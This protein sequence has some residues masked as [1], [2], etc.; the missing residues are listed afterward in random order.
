MNYITNNV[1]YLVKAECFDKKVFEEEN[2]ETYNE[3]LSDNE[4]SESF[5]K[6]IRS[7]L[8]PFK[9]SPLKYS[10][11]DDYYSNASLFV[12]KSKQVAPTL[13]KLIETDAYTAAGY[14]RWFYVAFPDVAWWAIRGDGK[15]L[16][17]KKFEK[18]T[19]SELIEGRSLRPEL[20]KVIVDLYLE[21]ASNILE[22]EI[23]NDEKSINPMHNLIKQYNT[24][25][26]FLDDIYPKLVEK[27]Y[28]P[29]TNVNGKPYDA[30]DT[31]FCPQS[32]SQFL[33]LITRPSAPRI[34]KTGK[35]GYDAHCTTV[36]MGPNDIEKLHN[37]I[38]KIILENNESSL[39]KK[40]SGCLIVLTFMLFLV[41]KALF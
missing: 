29:V 2:I 35:N 9:I 14:P 5:K 24:N 25:Q 1:D 36:V 13:I 26:E 27:G 37:E 28:K 4:V 41:I 23:Y 18:L 30:K 19:E 17:F 33:L 10:I 34:R 12:F 32:P 8:I 22:C 31:Y 16:I 39:Q 15:K 3:L 40:S 6:I 21:K 20:L 7:F 11:N 38:N